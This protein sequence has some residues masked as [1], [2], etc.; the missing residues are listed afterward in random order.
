MIGKCVYGIPRHDV[1]EAHP[2]E[3]AKYSGFD[4]EVVIPER[5]LL[6]IMMVA[7]D[8]QGHQYLFEELHLSQEVR[9]IARP[10]NWRRPQKILIAGL[11]KSGTTA[12]F[13]KIKNSIPSSMS[14][15]YEHEEYRPSAEDD[16][17]TVLAKILFWGSGIFTFES[18][19][20]GL[21][22]SFSR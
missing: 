4:G 11:A 17:K 18:L 9:E 3:Q 14:V 1:Y 8:T 21:R 22:I 19:R 7:V 2:L 16:Q 6:P 13:Y 20:R 5:P 15:L 10:Q 12:L